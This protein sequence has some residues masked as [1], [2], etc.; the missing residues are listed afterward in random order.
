MNTKV[1]IME[2]HDYD[3]G[4]SE[5]KTVETTDK[6]VTLTHWHKIGKESK[7]DMIMFTPEEAEELAKALN[8][9]V[10]KYKRAGR[11]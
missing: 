8:N 5:N 9:S 11:L 3:I 7:L 10:R 4:Y 6:F 2:D 1:K